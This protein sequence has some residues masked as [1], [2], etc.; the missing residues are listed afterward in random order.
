MYQM[1]GFSQNLAAAANKHRS[2]YSIRGVVEGHDVRESGWWIFK[3]RMPIVRIRINESQLAAFN[4]ICNKQMGTAEGHNLKG[5]APVLQLGVTEGELKEY[6]VG[7]E[8]GITFGYADPID[9][10][11][12]GATPLR[13]VKFQVMRPGILLD[14]EVLIPA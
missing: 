5:I 4:A 10:F 11:F 1:S 9:Q 8:V 12:A 14:N 13:V 3:E 2:D 7:S 6:P